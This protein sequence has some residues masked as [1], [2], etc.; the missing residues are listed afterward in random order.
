MFWEVEIRREFEASLG[1]KFLRTHLNQW[2]CTV[3]FTCHP[4]YMEKHK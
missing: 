1:K 3:V 2:L 4:S